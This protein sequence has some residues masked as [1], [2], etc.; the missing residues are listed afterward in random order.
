MISN[1]QN[2]E[3]FSTES[4]N[5]LLIHK[6]G[7]SQ[8]KTLL[9]DN[10]K[11]IYT[12]LSIPYSNP[13]WT[14]IRNP[15]DRFISGLTYDIFQVYGNLN[16]IEKF[17]NIDFLKKTCYFINNPYHRVKGFISHTLPQW[18]Y[19]FNQPL[20]FF[21]D[22][23]DLDLFIP[24]HFKKQIKYPNTL[25]STYKKVIKDYIELHP[26]LYQFVENFLSPDYFVY[27]HIKTHSLLWKWQMGKMF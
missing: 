19:L 10:S 24:I 22:I 8:I 12:S 3:V 25:S 27:N 11:E 18:T 15:Y 26:P 5:Y 2:I 6:N 21:V 1:I 20:N 16:N 17:L 7:S 9:K 13:Y 14:T 23:S 4:S